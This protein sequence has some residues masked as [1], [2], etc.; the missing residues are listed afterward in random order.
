MR[1]F[2]GL[3]LLAAGAAGA[4]AV[5]RMVLSPSA[6]SRAVAAFPETE[7][8]E[9]DPPLVW[10]DGR[11]EEVGDRELMLRDG[12]GEP[13]PVERFAGGATRIYRFGDGRWRE[14]NPAAVVEPGQEVCVQAILE[15][16][17]FLAVSVFLGT[18]CGPA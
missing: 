12:Q 4:L 6:E 13:V 8:R 17:A 16:T 14:L 18:G 5:D 3:V 7:R 9:G 15:E 11:L 2:A 10:I 1:F